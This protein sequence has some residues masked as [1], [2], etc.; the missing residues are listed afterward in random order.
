MALASSLPE[1]LAGRALIGIANGII[2]VTVVQKPFQ[3]GYLSAKWMIVLRTRWLH[4]FAPLCRKASLP[5]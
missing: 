2:Q 4:F 3:F 5:M 1:L